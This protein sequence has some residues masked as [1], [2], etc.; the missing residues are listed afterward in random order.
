MRRYR[1]FS[2]ATWTIYLLL[3]AFR[4]FNA[5]SPGYI[6]PDEFFQSAEITAGN[7]FDLDVNIPW[8]YKPRLPC[9]SILIPAITTGIPYLL[10][11]TWIGTDPGMIVDQEADHFVTSRA[12]FITQRLAFVLISLIIDWAVVRMARQIRRSP[13]VA[14]LLV[15]SSY[16][17][18]A[19]H[20]HPFSNTVETVILALCATVLSSIILD[21][22]SSMSPAPT[23][24]ALAD[25]TSTVA[26]AGNQSSIRAETNP[27]P[28]PIAL[29]FLLGVLFAVGTFTRITFVV[30]GFPL[31]VMFLYLNFKA[32]FTKNRTVAAGASKFIETCL[33]LAL[34]LAAM[35]AFA[36]LIDSIY[37]HK[38][39]IYNI[40]NG[41]RLSLRDI[42]ITHPKNWHQLSYKG[43]LTF[44]MWNNLRYNLD[45]KNLAEHGLHPRFL[46]LLLNFPVLFGNLALIAV[47]TLLQ[48]CRARE[49]SS[50]SKLVTTLSYSGIFGISVLST[51]PHQEARF[52]T[53][54]ILPLIIS[55]SGRIS[56]L[57]RKFWPLW[58]LG[59]GIMALVLGLFHQSGLVPAMEIVQQQ[60]LGFQECREVRSSAAHSNN[61]HTVC[62]TH[63]EIRGKY[64]TADGGTYTTHVIFYK[65]YL[66]PQHLLGYNPKQAQSH[67]LDL[68]V[69]DWREKDR[70]QLLQDLGVSDQ[71]QGQKTQEKI[72][73]VDRTLIG[74]VQNQLEKGQQA[75][76][77]R[78]AGPSQWQRTI[79]IAPSTVDFTDQEFYATRD[80][81]SRHANFDHIQTILQDP[82]NSLQLHI[83]YL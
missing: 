3:L 49:W 41:V 12:L 1:P 62:F 55:L 5:L 25:P 34:G 80:Q 68:R 43:S 8:E 6:H 79:L 73:V 58:L 52:L 40:S 57:G 76:L 69:S 30:Y 59:N 66:P 7:I 10:L 21:H 23:S 74:P 24:S 27:R 26:P 61:D 15:S 28:T 50:Q 22:D 46:H 71:P 29:S 75:L 19:Y 65:T 77:F 39:I 44:T 9:R 60:A 33:P 31:G 35:S 14:L 64:H 53:P 70:T 82:M 13:S 83:F 78:K 38:L 18:L 17:T 37:F 47:V 11:K 20:T 63:D 48:K 56:K 16:V 32:T 51:M 42:L 36:V 45:E 54:L 81:I 2:R 4:I 72:A 67:G